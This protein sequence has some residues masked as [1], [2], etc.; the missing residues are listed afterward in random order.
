MTSLTAID[1]ARESLAVARRARSTRSLPEI[2]GVATYHLRVRRSDGAAAVTAFSPDSSTCSTCP[3]SA[4]SPISISGR[5]RSRRYLGP[6]DS[7]RRQRHRALA[8]LGAGGHA[9]A[10]AGR[11][12]QLAAGSSAG[13]HDVILIAGGIGL[14][15]LRPAIDQLLASAQRYGRVHADLRRAHS[16][17]ACFTPRNSP[18]GR[19]ADSTCRPRSTVRPP[20]GRATW[21]WCRCCSIACRSPTPRT[22]RDSDLRTGSD[23]AL[24]GP[25]ALWNA[26]FR[27]ADLAVAGAQHAMRRRVLRALPAWPAFICKDGPVFRYDRDRAR[28]ARGGSVMAAATDVG[29][30]Q[31]RLVRRLPAFAAG[32]RRRIARLWPRGSTSSISWKPPATSSRSLRRGPG[33]RLDHHAAR[34]R[35]A[36]ARFGKQARFLVTIGACAT[37]GGIQALRNWGDSAEFVQPSTPRPEYIRTL[38]TLDRHRRPRAGRFRAA[39]LPDQQAATAGSAAGLAGRPP[40]AH[41]EPQRLPRLQAAG[42]RVRHGG[43]RN[44]LPG[45]GDASRLRGD[46]PGLRPRLLRLLWP[47]RAA[48]PGQPHGPIR[49]ATARRARRSSAACAAS[50]AMRPSSAA[51]EIAWRQVRLRSPR[52]DLNP[53]SIESHTHDRFTAHDSH[54]RP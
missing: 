17:H 24:H 28:V 9:R 45:S 50:T 29:R 6:H 26:A 20:A 23:D 5:S 40:A 15:P 47:G 51:K 25:H 35:S 19:A 18:T 34:R 30:V 8:R 10:C 22:D 27:G 37:A 31:V 43:P 2:A 4:K 12:A 46:L 36:S 41:A 54:R 38:D 53:A 3:A 48:E 32:C 21:A 16:R 44:A 52:L 39:R 13:A 7:R 33:R 14:A 49:A 42:H 1:A 11:S